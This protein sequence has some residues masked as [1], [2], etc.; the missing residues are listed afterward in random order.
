[1]VTLTNNHVI[2]STAKILAKSL[3]EIFHFVQHDTL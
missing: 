2:L 1:M 3:R